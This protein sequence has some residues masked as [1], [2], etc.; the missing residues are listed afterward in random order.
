ME[1]TRETSLVAPGTGEYSMIKAYNSLLPA[2]KRVFL[3]LV[4][5]IVGAKTRQGAYKRVRGKVMPTVAEYK[6]ITRMAG[7]RFS[8]KEGDLWG[9]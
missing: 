6:A 4:G 5:E 8:I 1:K 2:E 7:E 9:E 3:R